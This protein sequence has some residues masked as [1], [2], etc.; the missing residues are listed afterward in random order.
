MIHTKAKKVKRLTL[1]AL[2]TNQEEP[3]HNSIWTHTP[4][5]F[6]KVAFLE[7]GDR[8]SDN[9]LICIHGFTRNSRDFDFLA[10]EL[11]NSFHIICPDLL[12]CGESGYLENPNSY[13]FDQYM[14][15]LITLM[16][17]IDAPNIHVLG[18][19]L[20][21]IV[22]MMLAA[23]PKSPI[24]S[25]TLND[26]GM[27][28]PSMPLRRQV[29]YAQN[30]NK[31]ESLHEAKC[32]F[33][34][35]LSTSGI[36]GH[37]YWDHIT[38][39]GIRRDKEGNFCLAHDPALGHSIKHTG[40]SSLHFEAYWKEIQCPIHIIRGETS[41]F[42][43]LDI[44]SKMAY[45]QKEAKISTVEHCGHAPSLMVPEQIQ[46]VSHWLQNQLV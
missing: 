24:K 1:Y 31:F 35:V 28:V 10:C 12:G 34:T 3:N 2:R 26:V 46:V 20:G 30:D 41:D 15:D 43:P 25:I 6:Q 17:R 13:S 5:G 4:Q 36:R 44:L 18:T 23:Q 37:H 40:E 29:M 22:A 32:Y 8:N 45:F 9:A 21:G 33:Q 39:Y 11:Q 27:I 19:S 42:L 7:W 14:K 16:A 38:Q